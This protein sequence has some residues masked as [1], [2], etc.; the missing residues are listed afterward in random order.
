MHL[1]PWDCSS[2]QLSDKIRVLVDRERHI[3]EGIHTQF[4]SMDLLSLLDAVKGL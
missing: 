3:L 2:S 4:L 1:P